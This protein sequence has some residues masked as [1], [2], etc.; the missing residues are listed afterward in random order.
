M[1]RGKH[2]TGADAHLEPAASN[3][4][5]QS[6]PNSGGCP[7]NLLEPRMGESPSKDVIS[8]A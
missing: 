1:K 8:S 5:A 4:S 3:G 6:V 2:S 7:M